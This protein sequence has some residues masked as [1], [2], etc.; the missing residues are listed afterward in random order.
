MNDAGDPVVA[1]FGLCFLKD[2][3]EARV[4][5]TLE[6]VGSRFYKPPEVEDGRADPASITPA[7]D[8]YSL[9]KLL[10]WM[11]SGR[12][13]ERE[14]Y[15]EQAFDIRGIEPRVAHAL[16][17]EMLDR[18]IVEKPE[19]RFFRDGNELADAAE[20]RAEML[21]VEAHVL[22]LELPQPCHYCRVGLYEI[23]VDPRWWIAELRPPER[24]PG[25]ALQKAQW[26]CQNLG[27]DRQPQGAALV[28]RCKNCG[29][30]QWFDLGDAE[31]PIKNWKLPSL[32]RR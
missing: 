5:E 1:D 27:L 25:E 17:Y 4:T 10:Y 7:S 19:R 16:V 21:A 2:D 18:S 30:L 29:N 9:G 32:S 26:K 15:R 6:V 8:V 31:G 14:K 11:F 28:L 3:S 12:V 24:N 13:F 20:T 23:V 22:G